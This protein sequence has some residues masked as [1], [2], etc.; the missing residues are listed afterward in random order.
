MNCNKKVKIEESMPDL[1]SKQEQVIARDNSSDENKPTVP[2][3]KFSSL[4]VLNLGGATNF[5]INFNL[6]KDL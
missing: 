6:G 5:T 4:P 3:S 1:D 2:E